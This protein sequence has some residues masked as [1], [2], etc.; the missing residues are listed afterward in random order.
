MTREFFLREL[1]R[2]IFNWKLGAGVAEQAKNGEKGT[3]REPIWNVLR[4]WA[5]QEQDA[6][7]KTSVESLTA[8]LR[9]FSFGKEEQLQIRSYRPRTQLIFVRGG[10][11]DVQAGAI[12]NAANCSLLGGGGVDGAIHRAAGP[13][14]LAECRT[15]HGCETGQAK[16][17]GAHRIRQA[18][19]IIHAVGPVYHG[20]AEDAA[21]LASCYERSLDLAL[22]N[23]C[24]SI[25]FPCI[26][27]GVY[28]YPLDEAA[29]VS[30]AAVRGWADRH[31]D[32]VMNVY[33]CCFRSAEY[34]A[35]E[36][37][38]AA[39]E[40]TPRESRKDTA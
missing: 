16:I 13:A 28:G 32:A 15:L 12:V 17:T 4:I 31:P 23:G 27:T 2:V 3:G 38:A 19:F 29:A 37:A 5:D 33:F 20:R 30:L 10:V 1:E 36:K 34:A 22:G 6:E 7:G 21:L 18:D 14:L 26:S 40:K 11:L 24:L 35:Y 39:A 9:E 25:A 8:G